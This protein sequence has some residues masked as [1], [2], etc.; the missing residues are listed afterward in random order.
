MVTFPLNYSNQVV[1]R[2]INIY[3]QALE[4]LSKR[5][6]GW[7]LAVYY[8][9][10]FVKKRKTKSPCE[11]VDICKIDSHTY[12]MRRYHLGKLTRVMWIRKDFNNMSIF[13]ITKY[14]V[15]FIFARIS[16]I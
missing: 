2:L 11:I 15:P 9:C 16:L 8:L 14:S 13:N 7:Y 4:D 12:F 5:T 1:D 3:A 10:V 6:M